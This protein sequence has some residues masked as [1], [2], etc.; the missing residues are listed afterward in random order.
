LRGRVGRGTHKSYCFLLSDQLGEIAKQRVQ[1][2]VTTNDGF[3]IAR[4][5]LELR[6]PGELLGLKQHGIPEFKMAD[7]IKN[8]DILLEVQ[9]VV[10]KLIKAYNKHEDQAI[11]TFIEQKSKQILD[12]YAND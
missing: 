2:M 9:A 5:D 10:K 12:H 7:I 11:V 1:T 8:N 6:G 3:E 4:K